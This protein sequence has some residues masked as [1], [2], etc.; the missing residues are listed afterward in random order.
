LISKAI[1]SHDEKFKAEKLPKI[2][3]DAIKA[4]SNEGKTPE[5][6]ALAELQA[7]FDNLEIEKARAEMSSKYTKVLTE[8]G[9]N[10]D[11]LNFIL[12]SDDET[13]NNN[14]ETLSSIINSSVTNG[15]EKEIT[16]DPP[17]PRAGQGLENLS[18]VEQSFYAKNPG[19]I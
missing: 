13:T 16:K 17:M 6:I 3:E 7:K 14:I 11:L 9:L 5:Q 12:G 18:G 15:I 19:L 10:A 4:K 1:N 2:L 8:K